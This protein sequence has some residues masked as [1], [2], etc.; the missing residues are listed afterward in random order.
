M[1]DNGDKPNLLRRRLELGQ[2]VDRSITLYRLNFPELLAIAAITLPVDVLNALVSGSIDDFVTWAIASVPLSIL[3]LIVTV[4]A[5]AAI[6]R[7]VDD[8][9]DARPPDFN[10]S[11]RYVWKRLG[12]LLVAALRAFGLALLAA[13]TI[14]GIPLAVYLLVRWVFFPQAIAIDDQ[15]SKD[16]LDLSARIVKGHWWRTFGILLVVSLLASL[17]AIAIGILFA[18]AAAI[19]SGLA[20][21]VVAVIVLPFVAGASTLLYFDLRSRERES[22]GIA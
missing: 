22:A 3:S 17:P 6:A 8:I 2:I 16:A 1:K 18:P 21:A 11:Y 12:T 4:V 5:T 19:A 10:R 15:S 9:A 20:S 7:A 13:V 14:V